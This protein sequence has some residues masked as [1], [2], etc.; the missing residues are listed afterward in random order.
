MFK[1][2]ENFKIED[3]HAGTAKKSSSVLC[4]NR[5]SLVLRTSGAVRYTFSDQILEIYPGDIIFMPRGCCYDF[6]TLTDAPC[7]YVSVR[8]ESDASETTPFV[9][10]IKDFPEY[11]EFENKLSDMW[12]FG[13]PAE[14]YRC[15]SI[16]YNLLAY[17]KNQEKIAYTD[18]KKSH[19]ISPAVSYLKKHIYDCDLKID[20]LIQLCGISGTYFQKIFQANYSIS[21]QKY[22]LNK[23]LSHAKAIMDSGDFDTISEIATSVGYTDPLYFSRAFKKK[24]G[25]SPTHY[26]KQV[27][28]YSQ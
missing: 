5:S 3:I 21:P 11:T 25:F 1:N 7:N 14:R 13:G 23:R 27:S 19:L 20:T 28:F 15:Y 17:M 12:K 26:I 4:R 6:V 24:Y 9:Y 10:S 8:I 2:I 18:K 22:I 16:I